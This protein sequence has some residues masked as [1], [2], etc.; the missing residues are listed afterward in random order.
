M[1]LERLE[2]MR[3][4]ADYQ[5]YKAAAGLEGL[6]HYSGRS[7]ALWHFAMSAVMGEEVRRRFTNWSWEG[8]EATRWRP[9]VLGIQ[10]HLKL[11]KEYKEKYKD[12]ISKEKPS[13]ARVLVAFEFGGLF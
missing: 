9:K 1:L 7:K 10:N 8:L 6:A 4:A 2:Y 12:K 11:C 13:K 5:K 3:R